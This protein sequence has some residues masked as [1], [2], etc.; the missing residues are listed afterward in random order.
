MV[1]SIER[2]SSP[3]SFRPYNFGRSLGFS[4]SR[5]GLL[6][7]FLAPYPTLRLPGVW[8]VMFWYSGLIAGIVTMSTV[9]PTIVASP[10]YLW[11]EM[12]D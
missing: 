10:P 1:S 12:L 2:G 9:G 7:Q 8:L 5:G 11:G 6:H 3:A 4:S